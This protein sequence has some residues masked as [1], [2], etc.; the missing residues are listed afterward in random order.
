MIIIIVIIIIIIIITDNNKHT[1]EY[2]IKYPV[3]SGFSRPDATLR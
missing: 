1:E 3:S 2:T